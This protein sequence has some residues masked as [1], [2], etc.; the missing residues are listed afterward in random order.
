MWGWYFVVLAELIEEGVVVTILVTLDCGG[1][2]GGMGGLVGVSGLGPGG[3]GA[4][5][6]GR[7]M[8]NSKKKILAGVYEH[9]GGEVGNENGLISRAL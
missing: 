4:E 7:T 5:Q 3:R 8:A 6:P 2:C 1:F 9:P